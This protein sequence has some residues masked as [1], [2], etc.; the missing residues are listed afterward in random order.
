MQINRR[1]YSVLA[2]FSSDDFSVS[3][4]AVTIKSGGVTN[5]QLAGS[6]A[7]SKL[8][9]ITTADKVSGA[10]VQIDGATDGT[11]ITVADSDKLLVDDGG[12][13]KYINASQIKSYAASATAA[14]DDED[15]DTMTKI[16]YE[17]EEYSLDTETNEVYDSMFE[18][19]G[20]W[21]DGLADD[22]ERWFANSTPV[23]VIL[24]GAQSHH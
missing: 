18:Y 21:R 7:D 10:A 24:F 8:S 20:I 22:L 1:D 9:T 23:A 12:T 3:S 4:G 19:K 14:D 2:S 5:T 6:I 15:D 13:T 11:S 16:K 17:G